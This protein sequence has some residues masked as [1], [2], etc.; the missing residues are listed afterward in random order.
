MPVSLDETLAHLRKLDAHR[1]DRARAE[2]SM[3]RERAA[4]AASLLRRDFGAARVVLFGSVAGETA[5][6]ESDVDLAVEGVASARFW[7]AAAMAAQVCGRDVHLVD[8]AT[9]GVSL[10]ARIDAEGIAL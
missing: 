4:G 1:V 5:T 9:V 10:R 2:S 8:L 3:L 6:P 7:R